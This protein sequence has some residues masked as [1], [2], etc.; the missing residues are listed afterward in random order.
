MANLDLARIARGVIHG[1]ALLG[2]FLLLAVV[3]MNVASVV[4]GVVWKPFPGDFE[5]TEIGVAIAAFSFLPYCQLTDA[6]VTADIF[7]SKASPGLIA[8]F[9][10]LAA[11]VALVFALLLLWRMF[12]GMQSQKD[13][14]Y[15]TAILQFPIWLGFIPILVSL[16]L[17]AVAAVITLFDS[18]K[19]TPG[20][21]PP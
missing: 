14:G 21:A 16:A 13:Y 5:L 18:G 6:N 12:E 17:L 1:W 8:K 10:K 7:T 9:K 20:G 2:G 11:L 15:M 3:L 19:S 4:G